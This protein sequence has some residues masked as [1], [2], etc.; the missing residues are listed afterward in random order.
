MERISCLTFRWLCPEFSSSHRNQA[1]A[2]TERA[3][4]KGVKGRK[5]PHQL[6]KGL[7][8]REKKKESR[9]PQS[10]SYCF[11]P[12]AVKPAP[13]TRAHVARLA[14]LGPVVVRTV[15]LPQELSVVTD[16]MHVAGT[17]ACA[18]KDRA[19]ERGGRRGKDTEGPKATALKRVQPPN[20]ESSRIS[21]GQR[22]SPAIHLMSS[23][24]RSRG[25]KQGCKDVFRN[26]G[27]R[28]GHADHGSGILPLKNKYRWPSTHNH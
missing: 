9:L 13:H 20:S 8:I 5:C 23:L 7:K 28:K 27:G 15:G 1:E 22:Q 12:V 6:R 24:H 26:W 19:L 3:A 21:C 17:V 14:A 10:P 4:L 16:T 25:E 11:A 18:T 2:K